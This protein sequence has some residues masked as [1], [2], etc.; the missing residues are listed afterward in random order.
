MKVLRSSLVQDNTFPT[1][2][3]LHMHSVVHRHDSESEAIPSI[4]RESTSGKSIHRDVP[5]QNLGAGAEQT[6]HSKQAL[7]FPNNTTVLL[8]YIGSFSLLPIQYLLI[9][10]SQNTSPP[11]P[12]QCRKSHT[13]PSKVLSPQAQATA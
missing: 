11:S 1:D 12:K 2:L 3:T 4:Q 8:V 10:F 6:T 5:H 7:H 9:E 13:P